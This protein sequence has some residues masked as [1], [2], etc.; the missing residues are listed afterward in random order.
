MFNISDN[1]IGE[2]ITIFLL[3]E[4]ISIAPLIVSPSKRS[5]FAIPSE[6]EAHTTIINI[7]YFTIS[8]QIVDEYPNGKNMNTYTLLAHKN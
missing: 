1:F 3:I 2:L 7:K 8:G 4:Y 6:R 5:P